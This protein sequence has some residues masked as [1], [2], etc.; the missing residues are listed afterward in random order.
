MGEVPMFRPP[1]YDRGGDTFLAGETRWVYGEGAR[2]DTANVMDVAPRI[3]CAG[4]TALILKRN[5]PLN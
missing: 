2:P 5:R 4:L 3:S 1:I